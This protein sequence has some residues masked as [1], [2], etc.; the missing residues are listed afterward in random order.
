MQRRTLLGLLTLGLADAL[1]GCADPT[2]ILNPA[3]PRPSLRQHPVDA[4]RVVSVFQPEPSPPPRGSYPPPH[5]GPPTTIS[6]GPPDSASRIAIT[7][8]DGYDPETVAAYVEFAQITGTH[9]TFNPNGVYADVW[10]Q[11]APALDPLIETGQVQIGNHTF[12]HLDL[13]QLPDARVEEELE[14][15]NDWIEATFG[16]TSRPW[17]R[18]PFG[19]HDDRTDEIAGNLGYTHVLMWNGSLGDSRLLTPEILLEQAYRYIRGGTILLG[20]ANHPTV[21]HLYNQL[22]ELIH[23]R[24]LTP[25]TLDEMFGTS[26]KRG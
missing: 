9:I 23:E 7:I 13:K 6:A 4:R 10:A 16:T 17:Y 2:T 18:P 11:H 14:R 24:G 1:A 3:P 5:P 21:T 19:F 25:V 8:D 15:N 20:H 12:S 26:R 22:L